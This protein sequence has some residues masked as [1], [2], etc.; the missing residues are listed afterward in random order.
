MTD[1]SRITIDRD[2]CAGHGRCY[3]LAPAIFEPD[4]DGFPVV[5]AGADDAATEA[6]L[7][8]ARR[9]CPERAVQVADA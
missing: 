8:R 2:F 3:T 1:R 7:D 5:V 6:A 4:D 9:N